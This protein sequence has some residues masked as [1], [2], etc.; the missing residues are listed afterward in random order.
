MMRRSGSDVK[1]RINSAALALFNARG[2]KGT[3]TREIAKRAG[4]AEVTIYRHFRSK[5]EIASGLL[6]TYLERFRE[7]LVNAIDGNASSTS[8]LCALL[9]AFFEF[10]KREP[11]AYNYINL[12]HYNE[13]KDVMKHSRKPADIFMEVISEG[14][15]RGELASLDVPLATALVTGMLTRAIAFYESGIV[16]LSYDDMKAKVRDSVL[17]LLMDK[18]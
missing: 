15:E 11:K 3:T 8:K 6:F 9:D 5:K 12:A 16:E 7:R 17:R 14:V 18:G 2:I 1:E 13:L 10:A 4:V